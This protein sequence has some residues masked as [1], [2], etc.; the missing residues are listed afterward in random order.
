MINLAQGMID[1]RLSWTPLN[2]RLG[3][4][5]R[6]RFLDLLC[7]CQLTIQTVVYLIKFM[8]YN[9]ATFILYIKI[10]NCLTHIFKFKCNLSLSHV[11]HAYRYE[12]KFA[13]QRSNLYVLRL[14]LCPLVLSRYFS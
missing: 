7:N 4:T 14:V 9:L 8:V 2:I 12:P 6:E 3:Y 5:K 1:G 10:T 11:A 13:K